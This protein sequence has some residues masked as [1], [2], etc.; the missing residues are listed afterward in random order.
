MLEHLQRENIKGTDLKTLFFENSFE[1]HC[2][3]FS[4]ELFVNMQLYF[5]GFQWPC[6][7]RTGLG[8]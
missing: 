1:K 8:C 3:F 7:R 5:R 4:T 6:S 2:G